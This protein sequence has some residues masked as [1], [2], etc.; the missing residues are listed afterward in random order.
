MADPSVSV[1]VPV[2]NGRKFL[3]QGLET[4]LGQTLPPGELIVVDD[5]STDDTAE[6]ARGFGARVISNSGC[7]ASA[8]RNTGVAAS[9][10]DIIA[11]LDHDDLWEPPK[12]ERQI[13]LMVE[14]P[15]LSYAWCRT[16][17]LVEPGTERAAWVRD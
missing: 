12:L 9:R 6:I 8:A 14:Q 7:G 5:G 10:A 4:V 3:A 16:T 11:F 13:A 1:V 15:G 2:R 17:V